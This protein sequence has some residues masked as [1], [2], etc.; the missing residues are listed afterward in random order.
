MELNALEAA[1]PML[2]G[3]AALMACTV[4][5]LLPTAH[6]LPRRPSL[7]RW[8]PL[9]SVM[10]LSAQEAA[11]HLLPRRPSLPR[12]LPPSSVME[13]SAQVAAAPMLAGTA[14][15]MACTVLPLLQTAHMLNIISISLQPKLSNINFNL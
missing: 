9:S 8:L 1:A 11:A 7:Q 6:L 3:T 10:E 15:L 14:A 12:W 13:L 4:L 2:A 5:P